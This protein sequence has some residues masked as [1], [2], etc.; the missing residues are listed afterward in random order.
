MSRAA[1]PEST[2]ATTAEDSPP[3][4]AAP[5]RTAGWGTVLVICFAGLAASMM[6]TL[7]VPL[8]PKFPR[9][10][11]ISPNLASWLVT[12]ALVS[13]AIAT[14]VLSRLGDMFGKRR[15]LL[16]TLGL[17]LA[18]SVLCAT[19]SN[20]LVFLIG[21]A[22]QGASFATIPLGISMISA[23]VTPRRVSQGIAMMS[24]TLGIG[25]AL[26]LPFAGL[27][28]R[29]S[30]YH[31]LFWVSA[32]MAV[33]A[34]AMILVVVPAAGLRTPG[35]VD[36]V[37]MALLSAML[38]TL[39]LPLSYGSTWGWTSPGTLG[40]LT[41]AAVLAVLVVRYEQRRSNP[42]VNIEALRRRPVL[43]TNIASVLVGFSMMGNF[44]G[45]PSFL[46]APAATGYGFGASILVSGLCM[47][48]G[49]VLMVIAAPLSGRLIARRGA[50]VTLMLG[51]A[52]IAAGYLVFLVLRG[53][54]WGVSLSAAVVS[55]GVAVAYGAMP[56]LVLSATPDAEA[57]A[58]TGLNTLARSVGTSLASAA[59]GALFG[60]LTM[61]LGSGLTPT[62]AAFVLLFVFGGSAALL[63]AVVTSF[64]AKDSTTRASE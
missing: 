45:I 51:A 53:E 36:L 1:E 14:P 32:G 44:V 21:R 58:A 41:A 18:G 2:G 40:C 49:G 27:V 17:L 64:V 61:R 22:V 29:H 33:L 28:V 19:T 7:V 62:E 35:R 50:R 11:G 3:G 12:I 13:T 23:V 54:F 30:D 60:G 31:V 4:T 55:G 59:S 38:G 47:L 6:Q 52:L 10:L 46:Q 34:I 39:L 5:A 57:A 25:G 9:L 42:L 26:G 16:V 24:A 20:W 63:A 15:L 8:L 56:T 48:P 43:L 37:G